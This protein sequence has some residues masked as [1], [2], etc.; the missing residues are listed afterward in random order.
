M[1]Q[2]R[3]AEGI[4]GSS[5]L[6]PSD[7]LFSENTRIFERIMDFRNKERLDLCPFN[8]V[9]QIL[10]HRMASHIA[11]CWKNHPDA[12]VKRC[13]F[14]ATHIVKTPLFQA[15]ILECPDRAIV[16]RDIYR[17][18]KAEDEMRGRPQQTTIA[19]APVCD[20]DWDSEMVDSSY[21][22]SEHVVYKEITRPPPPGM[23]KAARRAW[24][25]KEIER[26]QRLKDGQPIEDLISPEEGDI[27]NSNVGLKT[28]SGENVGSNLTQQNNGKSTGA[29]SISVMRCDKLLRRPRIA[30]NI[31]NSK[32]AELD[33]PKVL[34]DVVEEV[35]QD[36][37]NKGNK[38]I[39]ANMKEFIKQKRILEKRLVGIKK[40]E[41]KKMDGYQFSREESI[42]VGKKQ[43]TEEQLAKLLENVNLGE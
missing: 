15:H 17:R 12:D 37:N 39:S 21:N 27:D 5:G 32:N 23:G 14:N 43:E 40:L 10:P 1:T 4:C 22:P 7:S 36:S 19:P 13:V 35:Q 33:N 11:K 41:K 20:E 28:S 8:A 9:H 24:R 25:A 26:V 38:G 16:E 34:N 31:F 3:S 30:A 29:T 6:R 2:A 42:K 18:Q